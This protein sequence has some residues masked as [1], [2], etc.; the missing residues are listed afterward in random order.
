M[1]RKEN[2][3]FKATNL[4]KHRYC[5]KFDVRKFEYCTYLCTTHTLMLAICLTYQNYL[6]LPIYQLRKVFIEMLKFCEECTTINAQDP[7]FCQAQ[8]QS[9]PSPVQLELRLALNLIITTPTHLEK[10]RCS[11]ILTIYRQQLA[12]GQ[13]AW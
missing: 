4:N 10:Q 5:A 12:G 3:F 7:T 6:Y 9:S 2:N 13:S 11:L 1:Q 8:F